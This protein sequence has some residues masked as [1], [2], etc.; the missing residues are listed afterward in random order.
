MMRASRWLPTLA[1]SAVLSLGF[2]A[3]AQAESAQVKTQVPGYYRQMVGG[4]EVTSLYDGP[5]PLDAK[6]LRNVSP[7]Q[8]QKRLAEAFRAN[9]TQTAVT[10]FLVNTGDKLVLVD[11]GAAKLFGPNLGN[12]LANLKA[13]GYD[14]AAVDAVLITHLHGDHV[15]GLLGPD[16][17][18]AFPKATVHVDKAEADYWLNPDIAAKAPAAMQGFFKMAQD[19]TAPYAKAGLLKTFEG[20]KE[21]LPGV[22]TVNQHGHTPGHTGYLIESKGQKM[23]F[24]GDVVHNLAVQFPD[25][26]V[27]IEFDGDPKQAQAVRYRLL[28]WATKEQMLVGGAHLPFPSIGHI[29]PD[30]KGYA[31]VPVDFSP[32]AP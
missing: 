25:P 21:I 32:V 8:V 5:I 19:S 22:K 9:P 14:P 24:W 1:F 28:G 6:L 23:L 15:G 11:A 3:L 4:I 29:R 31:W 2:T 26:S 18:P 10:A 30:R 27:T 16:G 13:S 7:A 17:Q 12:V 20:E